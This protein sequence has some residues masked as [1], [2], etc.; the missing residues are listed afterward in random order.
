MLE[1]FAYYFYFAFSID[2]LNL[3]VQLVKL[4]LDVIIMLSGA[5]IIF[6]L[7]VAYVILRIVAK[8]MGYTRL[9]HREAV[10]R[11]FIGK[12]SLLIMNT[13]PMGNGKTTGAVDMGIQSSQI[14]NGYCLRIGS[15]SASSITKSII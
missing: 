3:P 9:D 5:P 4:L 12:Q 8:N 14:S 2:L 1:F 11:E 6:W 10:N 13:G 7:V 15:K